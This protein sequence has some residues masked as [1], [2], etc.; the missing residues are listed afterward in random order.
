MQN[1]PFSMKKGNTEIGLYVFLWP[2]FVIQCNSF[3]FPN[4]WKYNVGLLFLKTN[5]TLVHIMHYDTFNII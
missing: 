2:N 5:I 1:D 3:S 4:L